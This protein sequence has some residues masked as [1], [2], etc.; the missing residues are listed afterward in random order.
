LVSSVVEMCF[1]K[2]KKLTCDTGVILRIWSVEKT[3]R[4]S[5]SKS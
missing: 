1:M 5:S 4:R 2:L 3:V